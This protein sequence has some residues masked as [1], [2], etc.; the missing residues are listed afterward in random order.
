VIARLA[1]YRAPGFSED[2]AM[3]FFND[4]VLP[5][6][7]RVSGFQEAWL[8]VSEGD[9]DEA[10][11]VSLWDT[12][13]SMREAQDMQAPH[14]ETREEIGGKRSEVQVYKVAHRAG[15]TE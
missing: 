12:E 15:P 14:R 1:W 8:L 10:L 11:A 7:R 3:A 6:L 5:D 2:K 4:R 9:S 13:E